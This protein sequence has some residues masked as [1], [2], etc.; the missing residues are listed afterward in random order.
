MIYQRIGQDVIVSRQLRQ[1]ERLLFER[2]CG[3]GWHREGQ[4]DV[5]DRLMQTA[6][7]ARLTQLLAS[8]NKGGANTVGLQLLQRVR[9]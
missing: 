5:A 1:G 9:V 3:L 2:V 8:S 6:V 4:D 7:V